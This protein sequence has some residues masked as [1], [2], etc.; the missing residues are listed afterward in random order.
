VNAARLGG[1]GGAVSAGVDAAPAP[2]P[3][4]SAYPPLRRGRHT[5]TQ[6]RQ[7]PR[8]RTLPDDTTT[9]TSSSSPAVGAATPPRRWPDLLVGGPPWSRSA[10][11]SAPL[12]PVSGAAL[13]LPPLLHRRACYS[14]SLAALSATLSLSLVRRLLYVSFPSP[15]VLRLRRRVLPSICS[16]YHL[17]R[18]CGSWSTGLL[19]LTLVSPQFSG[20]FPIGAPAAQALKIAAMS[21]SWGSVKALH[22][23]GRCRQR[24]HPRCSFPR[25]RRCLYVPFPFGQPGEDRVRSP[26]SGRTMVACSSLPPW[27]HRPARHLRTFFVGLCCS[28]PVMC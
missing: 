20:C 5:P 18:L 27:W 16:A 2:P 4:P 24:L 19:V 9:T 14:S 3:S 17:C 10:H 26:L 22:D 8:P 13:R 12:H 28:L 15:P 21:W 23:L 1:P 7:L 11:P 25:W 6:H